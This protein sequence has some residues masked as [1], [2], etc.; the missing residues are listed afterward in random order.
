[1][2]KSVKEPTFLLSGCLLLRVPEA[3]DSSPAVGLKLLQKES[4]GSEFW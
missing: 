1:M 2:E 3:E 4:G